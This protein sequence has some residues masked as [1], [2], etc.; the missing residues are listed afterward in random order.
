[1]PPGTVPIRSTRRSEASARWPNLSFRGM[2]G[3]MR[4]TMCETM[5]G[6]LRKCNASRLL[7]CLA[8]GVFIV[9]GA[10]CAPAQNTA[11]LARSG[12]LTP[13]SSAVLPKTCLSQEHQSD[14]IAAL[15]ES[16]QDHPTAGAYNTL[17]VLFTEADRLTCAG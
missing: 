7:P 1:M 10:V 17:G 8:L 11:P 14:K 5:R 12:K 2:R 9:V 15:M 4:G 3:T 16:I 13:K 6:T